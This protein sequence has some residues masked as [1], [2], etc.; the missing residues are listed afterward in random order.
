MLTQAKYLLCSAAALAALLI[1]GAPSASF[2]Q[3][4][5]NDAVNDMKLDSESVPHGVHNWMN[6]K[7]KGRVSKWSPPSNATYL[8]F[9]GQ[10]YE[11]WTLNPSGNSRVAIKEAKMWIRW[12][13]TWYLKTN[14]SSFNGGQYYE[15]Y[16]DDTRIE[17][18]DTRWDGS[19]ISV[20]AGCKSSGGCG[21]NYHFWEAN[22]FSYQ[23]GSNNNGVCSRFRFKLITHDSTKADDRSKARYLVAVG[24]D[25]YTN[26]GTNLLDVY[27]SRH[28]W[29]NTTWR[30]V[31]GHN[32]TESD[33]RNNPPPGL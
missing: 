17:P 33:F 27:M 11:D 4:A 13:S 32:L 5:V 23:I 10:V 21:R 20:R 26:N 8:A 3:G 31:Y 16:R 19:V 12:G 2:A 24:A 15:D 1:L 22:T 25:Y 6:W 28:K 14:T 29:A 30:T 9:W 7:Y 18:G